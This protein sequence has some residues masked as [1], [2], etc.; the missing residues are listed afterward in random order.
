MRKTVR[1]SKHASYKCEKYG[2]TITRAK[3][4]AATARKIYSPWSVRTY[5]M[6][7]YGDAARY[8]K[9]GFIFIKKGDLVITLY[10]EGKEKIRYG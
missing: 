10:P 8:W 3:K 5:L 2:L 4:F 1:M 7:R 9:G 6:M